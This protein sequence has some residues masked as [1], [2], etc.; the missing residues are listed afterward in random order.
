MNDI[1]N[2]MVDENEIIANIEKYDD[3]KL[4]DMVI[5]YRYFGLYENIAKAAMQEL[6]LRRNVGNTFEYE[7][8][9]TD[10]LNGLPKLDF[11]V[12]SMGG[13]LG[14]LGKMGIKLK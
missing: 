5:T 4:A 13:V 12:K 1:E 6:A 10:N 8:Y 14:A 3:H 7:K 11:D 9:I 2:M